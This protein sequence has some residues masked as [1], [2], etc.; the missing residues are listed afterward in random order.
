MIPNSSISAA[1]A[2]PTAE[3]STQS[4]QRGAK[5]T[6]FGSLTSFESR[7]PSGI[8]PTEAEIIVTPTATGPASAPRP[9]S[10]H[11]TIRVT[12]DSKSDSST[13]IVGMTTGDTRSTSS[14]RRGAVAFERLDLRAR[15]LP[16][17]GGRLDLR[18]RGL[19]A[20]G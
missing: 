3:N 18:T 2:S 20:P 12:P 6:R 19:A 14:M 11:P 7:N 8:G 4:M 16:A 10:S 1:E 17:T 9:T 15:D 5:A 13:S